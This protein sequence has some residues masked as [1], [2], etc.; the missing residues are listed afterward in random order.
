MDG[1]MMD[2]S[3]MKPHN[4]AKAYEQEGISIYYILLESLGVTL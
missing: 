2:G 3:W 1:W 4:L